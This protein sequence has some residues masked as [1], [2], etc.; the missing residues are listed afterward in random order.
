MR[1]SRLAPDKFELLHEDGTTRALDN[2]GR[3]AFAVT[4]GSE[5]MMVEPATNDFTAGARVSTR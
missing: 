1:L 2:T 3:Q 5:Q 4:V